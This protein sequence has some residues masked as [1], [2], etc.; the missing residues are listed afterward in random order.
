MEFLRCLGGERATPP[1]FTEVTIGGYLPD[2]NTWLQGECKSHGSVFIQFVGGCPPPFTVG[3]VLSVWNFSIELLHGNTVFVVDLT[4]AARWVVRKPSS[5]PLT[6]SFA[7][8]C[9][10]LGG[11]T[12][13]MDIMNKSSSDVGYVIMVDI[14][15]DVARA[16]A[17]MWNYPCMTIDE[18]YELI[19]DGCIL[20]NIV[21]IGD[22]WDK[23]VWTI[24]SVLGVQTILTSPPCPPWS[25][26]ARKE[27]LSTRD[28]LV[29]SCFDSDGGTCWG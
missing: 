20:S 3:S 13:G 21:I 8:L 16:A 22:I 23:R 15:E 12:C 29:F 14:N 28:G 10:G 4:G 24:I 6:P 19:S 5:G 17:H 9:C 25:N 1:N 27:G 11:W 2:S 18:A 26:A 7:E